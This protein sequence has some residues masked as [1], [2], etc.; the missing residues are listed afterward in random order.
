MTLEAS[1]AHLCRSKEPSQGPCPSTHSPCA[2][3]H[4]RSHCQAGQ[5]SQGTPG[6][7]DGLANIRAG[8]APGMKGATLSCEGGERE[9][10]DL[11]QELQELLPQDQRP[12]V[13]SECRGR[14]PAP[15]HKLPVPSCHTP[16][17]RQRMCSHGTTGVGKTGKDLFLREQSRRRGVYFQ[18]QLRAKG[19]VCWGKGLLFSVGLKAASKSLLKVPQGSCTALLS[20]TKPQGVPSSAHTWG[21]PPLPWKAFL[22]DWGPS[23]MLPSWP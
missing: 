12:D 15:P 8:E 5:V 18:A 16:D 3:G 19:F 1:R 20:L 22:V 4:Q 6:T 10:G 17:G 11:A 13:T 14:D 21:H 2:R 9:T 7:P 23:F